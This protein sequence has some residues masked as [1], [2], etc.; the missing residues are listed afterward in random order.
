[1]NT[2][3]EFITDKEL[4]AMLHVDPRTTL[5]WRNAGN[6]PPFIRAGAKRVLYRASDIELWLASRRFATR[7]SESASAP[8]AGVTPHNGPV[9]A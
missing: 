5:R 1:L 7:A 2:E 6:G 9:G 4:A 3:G 8:R